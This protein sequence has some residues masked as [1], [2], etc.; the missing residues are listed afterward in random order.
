M[1]DDAVLRRALPLG[2][3][4]GRQCTIASPLSQYTALT[5]RTGRTTGCTSDGGTDTV[6]A[7]VEAE[8]RYSNRTLDFFQSKNQNIRHWPLYPNQPNSRR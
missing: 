7:A 4:L 6:E 5:G 3:G 1:R 8:H 2:R